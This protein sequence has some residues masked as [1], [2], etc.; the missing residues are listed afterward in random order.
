MS[1]LR[2][3]PHVLII[4]SSPSQQALYLRQ[5]QSIA[6]VTSA[7]T[8]ATAAKLIGETF[9]EDTILVLDSTLSTHLDG[10]ELL[11]IA[12]RVSKQKKFSPVIVAGALTSEDNETLCKHGCTYNP[13]I[14]N[15][16]VMLVA[17]LI[18]EKKRY[19]FDAVTFY[20]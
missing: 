12:K 16:V 19:H 17:N 20:R 1:S 8:L 14:K 9:K 6:T 5:L 13:V 4:D 7:R 15:G 10:L 11:E 18:Q 3:K 2:K